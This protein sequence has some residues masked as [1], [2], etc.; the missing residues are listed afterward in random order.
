MTR[1]LVVGNWKMHGTVQSAIALAEAARDGSRVVSAAAELVLCP[2]CVFL[3]QV[4]HVLASCAVG[5]G[6]QNCGPAQH[7]AFTG[8]VS[9]TMLADLGC[10]WV[11][12]G[13]SERRQWFGESDALLGARLNAALEMGLRPILCVGEQESDRDAGRAEAVVAA[14]LAAVLGVCTEQDWPNRLVV[15]YEPVWAIGTG[16]AATTQDA[17]AMHGV[18]REQLRS[19]RSEAGSVPLLYGGS[20]RAGN[21]AALMAQPDIDGV[22]VGGASL[23]SEEFLASAAGAAV[24]A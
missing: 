12:I 5:L 18:V 14:Q 3:P 15:A 21:A 17:Q 8:E 24:A 22:L 11:L 19:L 7:G 20:V 9:A 4:A 6:A 13:H 23:D 16:R 1:A 10:Q 2:P